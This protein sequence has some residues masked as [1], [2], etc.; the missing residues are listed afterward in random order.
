[1]RSLLLSERVKVAGLEKISEYLKPDLDALRDQQRNASSS[2]ES[3]ACRGSSFFPQKAGTSK[4]SVVTGGYCV[5]L[6]SFP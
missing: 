4:H 2:F 6:S 3:S 1:M 5:R